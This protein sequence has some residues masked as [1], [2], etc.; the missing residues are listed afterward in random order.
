MVK[1]DDYVEKGLARYEEQVRKTKDTRSSGLQKSWDGNSCLFRPQLDK[2]QRQSMVQKESKAIVGR[3]KLSSLA[4]V[5]RPG[6]AS[7]AA[8]LSCGRP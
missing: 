2:N 5:S 1:G 4:H 3:I 8:S 7:A 6:T